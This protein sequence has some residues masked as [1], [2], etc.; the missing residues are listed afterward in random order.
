MTE[1]TIHYSRC[2]RYYFISAENCEPES[3]LGVEMIDGSITDSQL[4]AVGSTTIQWKQFGNHHRVLIPFLLKNRNDERPDASLEIPEGHVMVREYFMVGRRKRRL[5]VGCG[6]DYRRGWINCDVNPRVKADVQFDMNG[7]WPFPDDSIYEVLMDQVLE[8][9]PDVCWVLQELWRVLVPDSGTAT[10]LVPYARSEFAVSDPTHHHYFTEHS[11]DPFVVTSNP[12][13]EDF[14]IPERFTLGKH[15]LFCNS[16]TPL[17]R[18]RNAI[19]F[20]RVL[21]YLFNNMYDGVRFELRKST[22][23]VGPSSEWIKQ[24]G[25]MPEIL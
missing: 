12:D 1:P 18:W 2:G 11:M 22:G 3:W 5:N 13:T 24:Y 23:A 16:E 15:E 19:P 6:R 9:S 20:R 8:H 10:I 4:K 21:R 17:Q 25:D 7:S 14:Y